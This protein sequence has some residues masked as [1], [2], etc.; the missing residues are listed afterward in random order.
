MEWRIMLISG[1]QHLK[2]TT[3]S[4]MSP[5]D[6]AW[7]YCCAIILGKLLVAA[8]EHSF[9]YYKRYFAKVTSGRLKKEKFKQWQYEAV[10]KGTAALMVSCPW[11]NL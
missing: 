10:Q 4:V 9:V 7:H 8:V 11:K 3:F 6:M 1:Q 2:C 5:T